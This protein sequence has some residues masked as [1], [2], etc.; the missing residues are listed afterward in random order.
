MAEDIFLNTSGYGDF[1]SVD[2]KKPDDND[3]ENLVNFKPFHVNS[4]VVLDKDKEYSPVITIIGEDSK[5]VKRK[6]EMRLREQ[7]Q[8]DTIV[9]DLALAGNHR[10]ANAISSS[11]LAREIDNTS[12]AKGKDMELVSYDGM[13]KATINIKGS[14]TSFIITDANG[15]ILGSANSREDLKSTVI[16]LRYFMAI[17]AQEQE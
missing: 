15:E 9:N 4:N 14:G 8:I 11:A 1:I 12:Y 16:D 13:A 10:G 5:G 6:V 3:L 2:G 7:S 17:A